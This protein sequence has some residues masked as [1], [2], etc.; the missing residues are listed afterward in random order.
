MRAMHA[1]STNS[2]LILTPSVSSS[3]KRSRPALDAGKGEFFFL[4][5]IVGTIYVSLALQGFLKYVVLRRRFR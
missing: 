1:A 2:G 5:L 3:K 4:P